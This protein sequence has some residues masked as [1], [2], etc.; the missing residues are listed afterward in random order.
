MKSR[1]LPDTDISF[2]EIVNRLLLSM[3]SRLD[4]S[5]GSISRTLAE[6]YARE[7][8]TFYM[9]LELAH[10]SGYL[11]TAERGALDNV[12][13]L[14]D[15]KRARA[16]RLIGHVEFSRTTPAPNDIGIPAGFRVT[17]V[18]NDTAPLLTFE[19]TQDAVL[20]RGQQRVAVAVQELDYDP[21]TAKGTPVVNP[22]T[23]TVMPRG[24]FG[25]DSVINP[26]PLRRNSE[27]ETDASLRARARA[28]LRESEHGTLDAIAAAVRKAGVEHVTVVEPADGP[29]GVL[30]V[31]VADVGFADKPDALKQVEEAIRTSKAAGIRV[32]V[33]YARTIYLE[34]TIE[35]EPEPNLDEAGFDRLRRELWDRLVGF[36]ASL[37][38][39]E[40]L[41]RRKLEA[42]LFGNPGVRNIA[43]IK[44]DLFVSDPATKTLKKED[45]RLR[46]RGI[47]GDWEFGDL[48]KVAI[49]LEIKPPIIT[50]L[51]PPTYLFTLG[52]VTKKSERRSPDEIRNAVR[53]ALDT[54]ASQIALHRKTSGS[55]NAS[56]DKPSLAAILINRADVAGLSSVV[57]TDETGL[58]RELK[59]AGG[60]EI[61]ENARF[62]LGPV[63]L[64]E[65]GP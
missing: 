44:L 58:A 63:E 15:V 11:D 42:V 61:K 2:G 45:A 10:A 55:A 5:T 37:A 4:S 7:M 48:E 53:R 56:A 3:G 49:D 65:E 13:A 16:G 32:R 47:S 17:S 46:E 33:K 20:S 29:P 54:Y 59:D 9:M 36:T 19:T 25:I 40:V 51:R 41:S 21:A 18:P 26:A 52:I 6:A 8:A 14:L 60:A 34:P 62:L 31:V 1:V 39:G 38:V 43:G 12:V 57:I 22:S 30:E 64:V 35:V 24:V 27:D 28:A 50:R 23:L